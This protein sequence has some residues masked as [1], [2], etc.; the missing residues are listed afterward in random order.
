[1]KAMVDGQVVANSN[2]VIE[3]KGYQYFPPDSVRVD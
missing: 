2:D 3:C 1:M